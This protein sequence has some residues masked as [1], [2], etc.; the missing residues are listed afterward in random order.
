MPGEHPTCGQDREGGPSEVGV[1]N[2]VEDRTA[3][4]DKGL[5]GEGIGGNTRQQ[6][7]EEEDAPDT[8]YWR[9]HT[10]AS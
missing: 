10:R 6:G 2:Q 7:E 5:S 9:Q 8:S 3:Q 1:E 4:G